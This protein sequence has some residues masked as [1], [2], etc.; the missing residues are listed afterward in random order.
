MCVCFGHVHV[1]LP[2]PCS[3]GWGY[4]PKYSALEADIK[5]AVPGA[6]INGTVGNTRD[7]EVKVNGVLIYSKQETGKFPDF[8]AVSFSLIVQHWTL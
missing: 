1:T 8:Q 4:A 7:F 2:P 3:G 6:E 5:R